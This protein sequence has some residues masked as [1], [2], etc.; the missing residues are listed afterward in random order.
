MLDDKPRVCWVNKII[1]L[2]I[3]SAPLRSAFQGRDWC[4]ES[5]WL[6]PFFSHNSDLP[7]LSGPGWMFVYHQIRFYL[8]HRLRS[9]RFPGQRNIPLKYP[10]LNHSDHFLKMEDC[11][12]GALSLSQ[13]NYFFQ[14]DLICQWECDSNPQFIKLILLVFLFTPK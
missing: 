3:H 8:K 5:P 6:T 11:F 13:V 14:I 10:P 12:G 1:T 7:Q 2:V 9:Q 4:I